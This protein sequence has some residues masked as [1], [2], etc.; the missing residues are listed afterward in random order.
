MSHSAASNKALVEKFYAAFAEGNAKIMQSCYHESIVFQD[1]AFGVLVGKNAGDMWE[2]L[3]SGPR[4][5][6]DGNKTLLIEFS[7][8]VTTESTGSALWVARYKFS[9]TKRSVVNRVKATFEF[10]DGLIIKHT[11]VFK[12]W[13][14]SSQALGCSG[15]TL[16]WTS[17]LKNKVNKQANEKLEK[18]VAKKYGLMPNPAPLTLKLP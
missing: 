7:D 12:F 13:T 6:D 14:W 1:P 2:M 10:K 8:V 11:D 3:L 17:C 4:L 5:D 18:F 15:Y 9:A 16:G